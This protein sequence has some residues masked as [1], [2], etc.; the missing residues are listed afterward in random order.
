MLGTIIQQQ[1]LHGKYKRSRHSLPPSIKMLVK[2]Y[3]NTSHSQTNL[4]GITRFVITQHDM[5]ANLGT[6]IESLAMSAL[7]Y[8]NAIFKWLTASLI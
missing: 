2:I 6:W 7:P 8:F 3:N 1:R 4:T 5:N